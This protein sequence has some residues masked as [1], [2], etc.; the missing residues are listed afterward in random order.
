MLVRTNIGGLDKIK[1]FSIGNVDESTYN[2][3]DAQAIIDKIA[4][5]FA[6]SSSYYGIRESNTIINT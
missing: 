1:S 2:R 5:C 4:N 6:S 3:S